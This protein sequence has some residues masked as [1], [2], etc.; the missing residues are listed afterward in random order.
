MNPSELTYASHEPWARSK[1][2]GIIEDAIAEVFRDAPRE[3]RDEAPLTATLV[4]NGFARGDRP[5]KPSRQYTVTLSPYL[6]V[7]EVEWVLQR[8]R[9]MVASEVH[10]FIARVSTE[11]D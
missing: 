8:V 6:R 3:S 1:I 9:G 7:V 2:R 5:G 4:S 11:C 10:E